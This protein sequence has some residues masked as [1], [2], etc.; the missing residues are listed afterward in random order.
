M[1]FVCYYPYKYTKFT[2]SEQM[3]SPLFRYYLH[4][5]TLTLYFLS[6]YKHQHLPNSLTDDGSIGVMV[7]DLYAPYLVL[8]QAAY[9]HQETGNIALA[10]L[11][12]FSPTYV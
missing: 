5:S 8:A 9:L 12:P 6:L 11:L 3:F 4:Q 2:L 7:P 1:I 10:Y